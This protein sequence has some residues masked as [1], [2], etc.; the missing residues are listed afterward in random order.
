MQEGLFRPAE[1]LIKTVREGVTLRA[2]LIS[3][4]L[5]VGCVWWIVYS[6]MRTQVTEITSTSLPMGVVFLLF[7]LCVL[8]AFL[9]RYR[10]KELLSGSELAII[11]TLTA[12][13]SSLAGIGMVGFMLPALANP[14]YYNNP[15]NHWAQLAYPAPLFWAPHDKEAIRAFYLGQST[16]YR[17]EHI[18]AW[19]APVLYW[20][21]FFAALL[22]FFLCMAALLRRQ[23]IEYE[24]LSYPIIVL[25]MEMTL[26]PDGFLGFLRQRGML[27]G[28]LIPV[29]LQTINSLNYLFPSVPFIPVKP[30]QNGPLDL[31]PLFTKPPWNALGYFPLAFHPNTIGLAY[32]LPADVSFSCWFFYLLRKGLDVFCTAMGWRSPQ[33]SPMVNRIPYAPEQGVGA[34]LAM[35]VMV[36]WLARRELKRYGRAALFYPEKDAEASAMRK[37]VWG[38]VVCFGAMVFLVAQ[39]GMPLLLVLFMLVLVLAYLLALTRI[40]VDAGTAWHFGPFIPAQ[41]VVAN[42]VGPATLSPASISTL[43]FHEWYNLDYRS[44]TVP[45]LFEGYRMASAAQSSPRRLTWAMGLCMVV[46][47][48]TAC[49]A[50]LQLYYT[51]GAATAHVNPWRIQMG[52]IP[53]SLAQAHHD[54]LIHHPD[55][56]GIEGMLAGALITFLLFWAR[57][58]FTWWPFHPAGYAIGNTFITDLLWCPFLV[59][60]LA[61]VLIL[62]YGGMRAYRRALPFFIG[63]ILGDYV[64]ACIWSLAGVAFHLSMYRCFPN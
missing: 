10:G 64:I 57:S 48:F 1:V 26:H 19:T 17:R 50:A 11:Y 46:G 37:M 29:V 31:G 43:A 51:Y 13:G 47:Y 40:R 52:Q 8:N 35:A 16:I 58:R 55:W 28:I 60:W 7:L 20:G 42:S 44:M 54:S 63:L 4:V 15:T 62:R 6:E 34:W 53:W 41:E 61:K 25:P 27:L 2:V 39:G 9:T 49:W 18:L 32:L 22:G 38:A 24:R 5:V 3:L 12:V 33:T 30:T 14:L 59:G 56:P 45:H 23:W 21:A 36:L